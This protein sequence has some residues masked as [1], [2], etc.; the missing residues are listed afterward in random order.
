MA[1]MDGDPGRSLVLLT[2]LATLYSI[3]G[4]SGCRYYETGC[5]N[6]SSCW[7]GGNGSVPSDCKCCVGYPYH[8]RGECRRWAKDAWFVG[9]CCGVLV[10]LMFVLES[11]D[12]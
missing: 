5:A 10:P 2:F 11:S 4:A 9:L 12:N 7:N 1:A 8:P 3:V 6:P